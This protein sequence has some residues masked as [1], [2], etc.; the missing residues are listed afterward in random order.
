VKHGEGWQ[1]NSSVLKPENTHGSHRPKLS[2]KKIIDHQKSLNTVPDIPQFIEVQVFRK[3]LCCQVHITGIEKFV[4]RALILDSKLL[5][6]LLKK[7]FL[8]E[9]EID[10]RLSLS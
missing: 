7:S 6:I 4:I 2:R 10:P 9:F 5:E 3:M 8:N 1:F